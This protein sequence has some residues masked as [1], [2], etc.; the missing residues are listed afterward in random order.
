MDMAAARARRIARHA[1]FASA[2][3]ELAIRYRHPLDL[4]GLANEFGARTNTLVALSTGISPELGLLARRAQQGTVPREMVEDAFRFL[5][6]QSKVDVPAAGF[7]RG[8][9]VTRS[10]LDRTR[11]PAIL[12]L[13]E[14]PSVRVGDKVSFTV[15]TDADC[16][17]TV[18]NV[19]TLGR[20]TVLFPNEFEPEGRIQA[21]RTLR[22]PPKEAGYELRARQPGTEAVVATCNPVSAWAGG[23]SHD[24]E[25]QRFTVLGDYEDFVRKSLAPEAAT[26]A[27]PARR[28]VQR[29]GKP[30][31]PPPVRPLAGQVGR[32]GILVDVRP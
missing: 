31:P 28:R 8:I 20:A 26:P 21:Q 4:S 3:P 27:P 7:V 29:R 24:F 23:I 32:T 18:I 30:P 10:I 25:R 17:V 2:P 14:A 11:P 15:T 22:L 12:L 9:D 6:M 1:E 16:H 5:A 13:A 19:D